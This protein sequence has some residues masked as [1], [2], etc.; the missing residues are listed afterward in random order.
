AAL[1]QGQWRVGN[2]VAVAHR[3]CRLTKAGSGA[4][5]LPLAHA[6]RWEGG[7]WPRARPRDKCAG[8]GGDRQSTET[9]CAPRHT[10]T[11]SWPPQWSSSY[12]LDSTLAVPDHT[13]SWRA[14]SS[15]N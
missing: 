14:C 8:C 5:A 4:F 15:I 6:F 2:A 3:K 7:R 10:T 13:E 12:R 1:H 11:Q 9:A